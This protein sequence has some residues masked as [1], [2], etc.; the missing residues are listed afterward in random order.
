MQKKRSFL[1]DA[2]HK[3]HLSYHTICGHPYYLLPIMISG[4]SGLVNFV[5][6][7]K[8]TKNITVSPLDGNY[9]LSLS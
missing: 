3:A 7:Y 8:Q 6:N 5:P 4:S 1:P 9:L 2:E